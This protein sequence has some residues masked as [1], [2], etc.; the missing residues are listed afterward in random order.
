MVEQN[1]AVPDRVRS[2]FHAQGDACGRLGSPFTAAM[3][4]T[5]GDVLGEGAFARAIAN[6]PGDPAQDALALRA[7]GAFHGLARAG[8]PRLA[9]IYPPA[10]PSEALFVNTVREVAIADAEH[11]L[12]WLTSA[13]QTNEVGR[14]G[15]VLGAALQLSAEF[16][17]PME[18]LEV[19]ASA[20]VNLFFDQYGYDLGQGRR[21]GGNAVDVG[22]AC[23]W[24]GSPPSLDHEVTVVARAGSD[25]T[26]V[27]ARDQEA[28]ERMLAYIWPDQAERQARAAGALATVARSDVRVEAASAD[29]W[30][31]EKLARP[32]QDGRLRL[33]FHT[34]MWQYLP[35]E[36]ARRAEAAI[37]AAGARAT[38]G[39]PF[40]RFAMEADD[41]PRSAALT[42]TVWPGGT[43]RSLG[44]GDF[45]GRS[46]DWT[47]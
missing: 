30:L 32:Q 29:D 35:D 31:S 46:A 11:L 23:T 9:E 45:H 18:I 38:A 43:V 42:L 36:V 10:S 15:I 2:H 28:R 1:V 27:D 14:S 5:L 25:L 34:I 37:A 41:T 47:L 13:P 19:G 4:R 40:A 39:A 7:C 20:G 24:E 12:P 22:I 8:H 3:C 21:W 26:P 17:L 44:R 16:G 33:L 6:W